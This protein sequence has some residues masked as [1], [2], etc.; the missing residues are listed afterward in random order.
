M[1]LLQKTTLKLFLGLFCALTANLAYSADCVI[2]DSVAS[3]VLTSNSSYTELAWRVELSNGCSQSQS[4]DVTFRI[5]DAN[6]DELDYDREYDVYV[7]AKGAVTLSKSLLLRPPNASD[8]ISSREASVESEA[9]TLSLAESCLRVGQFDSRVLDV[10]STFEEISW[11]VNVFNDCAESFS[12]AIAFS[13][14]DENEFRIDY[15]RE[16]DVYVPRN[17][18]G[19]AWGRIL[20]D[21]ELIKRKALI[22]AQLDYQSDA[23]VPESLE[24]G[25]WLSSPVS[26]F[27]F[28]TGVLATSLDAGNAGKFDLSLAVIP[29]D[30]G[31]VFQVDP[32]SVIERNTLPAG[33]AEFHFVD[34]TMRIPV[35]RIDNNN[36]VDFIENF[37]FTLFDEAS[38]KLSLDSYADPGRPNGTNLVSGADTCLEVS[39]I[40]FV[41]RDR[42]STFT[43]LNWGVDIENECNEAFDGTVYFNVFDSEGFRLDYGLELGVYIPPN[44]TGEARDRILLSP[45]ELADQIVKLGVSV[46]ID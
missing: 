41:E 26:S 37:V 34:T 38:L 2:A 20:L 18:T 22:G 28:E 17:G 29:T 13:L 23:T 44:G 45:P 32:S 43:N 14:Y 5:F 9:Y 4:A 40:Q 39:D 8:L 1:N 42:N 16:F 35:V 27:N 30:T 24:S 21:A 3:S 7:P 6:Q 46:T 25:R 15:D 36:Q 11:K 10:N 33:S 19:K 12:T 31:M